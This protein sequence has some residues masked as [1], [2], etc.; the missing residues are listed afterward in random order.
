MRLHDGDNYVFDIIVSFTLLVSY[1][2]KY[3]TWYRVQY[4]VYKVYGI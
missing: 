2:I 4:I 3:G 1:D